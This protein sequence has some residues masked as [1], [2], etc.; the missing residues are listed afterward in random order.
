ME[1]FNADN[2]VL[3]PGRRGTNK[4][5]YKNDQASR[6]HPVIAKCP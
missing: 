5:V 4:A 6:D 1:F 2:A 3:L